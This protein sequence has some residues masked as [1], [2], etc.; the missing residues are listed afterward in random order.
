MCDVA[1]LTVIFWHHFVSLADDEKYCVNAFDVFA[2]QKISEASHLTHY[3]AGET[4]HVWG[5]TCV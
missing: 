4:L 5:E 1:E 3:I 2:V